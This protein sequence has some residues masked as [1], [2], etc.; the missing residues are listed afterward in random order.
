VH[1]DAAVIRPSPD[2]DGSICR[3]AKVGLPHLAGVLAVHCGPGVLAAAVLV[4]VL[5]RRR[6]A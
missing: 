5:V 1:R 4:L 3:K 6:Q 2:D